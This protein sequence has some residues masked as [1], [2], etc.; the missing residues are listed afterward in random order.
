[1]VKQLVLEPAQVE[2]AALIVFEPKKNGII[3]FCVDC[4]ELKTVAKRDSYSIFRMK[5]CNA[6]IG[7]AAIFSTLDAKSGYWQIEI[8]KLDLYR[9]A[10]TSHQGRYRFFCMPFG[11]GNA[12]GTIQRTMDANSAT[13]K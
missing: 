5:E 7:E 1:M 11:L 4:R 9:T 12:L 3:R 2:W 8:E 6:I 13:V 10:F